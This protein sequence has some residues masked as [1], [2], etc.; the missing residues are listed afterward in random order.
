MWVGRSEAVKFIIWSKIDATLRPLEAA[1]A[2]KR[3]VAYSKE[4]KMNVGTVA[5]SLS[6]GRESGTVRESP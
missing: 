5:D 6:R 3:S 1:G 2:K 4:N